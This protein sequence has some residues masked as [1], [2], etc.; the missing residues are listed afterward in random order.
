MDETVLNQRKGVDR[1]E[2][3]REIRK[4]KYILSSRCEAVPQRRD[5]HSTARPYANR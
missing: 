3:K 5:L 2:A 4:E 1:R